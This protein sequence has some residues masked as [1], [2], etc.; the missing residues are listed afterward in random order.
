[1]CDNGF[2]CVMCM[3]MNW[4]CVRNTCI[5][6]PFDQPSFLCFVMG[7]RLNA[8]LCLIAGGLYKMAPMHIILR[9]Q[10]NSNAAVLLDNHGVVYRILVKVK[11]ITAAI[12]HIDLEVRYNCL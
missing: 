1:M 10:C 12:D 2:V 5:T 7:P 11:R 4:L 8:L 6:T 9:L 3:I